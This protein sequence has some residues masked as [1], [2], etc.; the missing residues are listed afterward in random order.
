MLFLQL[1]LSFLADF[2]LRTL[3]CQPTRELRN[4]LLN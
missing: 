4:V 2:C 1:R 3:M